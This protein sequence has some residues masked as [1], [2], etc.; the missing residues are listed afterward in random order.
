MTNTKLALRRAT[1]EEVK[2]VTEKAKQ[3]SE[4]EKP[5]D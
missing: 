1:K 4:R 3:M 2:Q 5:S